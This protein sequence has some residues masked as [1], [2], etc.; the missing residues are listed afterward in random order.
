MKFACDKITT[1]GI[2]CM[3]DCVLTKQIPNTSC[4]L[5]HEHLIELG[6]SGMEEWHAC[7]PGHRAG[8]QGLAGARW[9]HQQHSLGQLAAQIRELVRILQELDDL[10]QLLF[11][12]VA[13]LDVVKL[14]VDLLGVHFGVV[15]YLDSTVNGE[16][17][18]GWPFV[19]AF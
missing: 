14:N 11:R 2:E 18:G 6:S 17:I 13:S 15:A 3:N 1:I 16:G 12:L 5:T 9:A 4:A 19:I 7:L 10:L 8:Q